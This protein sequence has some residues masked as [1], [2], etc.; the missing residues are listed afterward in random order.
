MILE[1]SELLK[2]KFELLAEM[3]QLT[4]QTV[5]TFRTTAVFPISE[6]NFARLTFSPETVYALLE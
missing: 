1:A 4:Y 3:E 5:P 2:Y 6:A